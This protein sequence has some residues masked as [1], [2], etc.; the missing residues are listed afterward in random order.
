MQRV[1]NFAAGREMDRGILEAESEGISAMTQ[2][3]PTNQ[4]GILE[5]ARQPKA[6][7]RRPGALT[8]IGLTAIFIGAVFGLLTNAVNGAVSPTYFVRIMGWY[9]VPNVWRASIQQGILEGAVVG[10][11]FGVVSVTTIG[12]VTRCR[13][14]YAMGAQWLAWMVLAILGAWLLGGV[15][16]MMLATVTPD[17]YRK[18]IFGV[19]EDP[20]EMLRYAWVGGSIVGA[21]VGGFLVITA[22]LVWFAIRWNWMLRCRASGDDMQVQHP[23]ELPST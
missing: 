20:V 21:E 14:T 7:P 3:Y 9:S 6:M 5:Y 17:F 18:I 22:G 8:G 12:V 23:S 15:S 10:L 13:C 2:G 16:A 1:H 4:L 11:I 19:P